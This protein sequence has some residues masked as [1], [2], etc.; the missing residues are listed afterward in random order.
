MKKYLSFAATPVLLLAAGIAGSHDN[1]GIIKVEADLKPTSEVP[2][3]SS[4]AS[5][6]FKATI[7]TVNQTITYELTYDGLEGTVQQSHIHVGQRSVNGGV[8]VFLCGTPT[9]TMPS[10]HAGHSDGDH[11]ASQYRG[12][13]SARY[14][15][16]NGGGQ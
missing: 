7:D 12:T 3:L 9:T 15:S 4:G 6:S 16:Y 13:R 11:H 2:V 5:G 10:R 1:H 14:C 8:S